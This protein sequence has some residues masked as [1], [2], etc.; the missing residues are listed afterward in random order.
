MIRLLKSCRFVIGRSFAV[1]LLVFPL[2]LV[3]P[4]RCFALITGGEGNQPLNDP[5]WPPGAAKV[6]NWPTRVAWWEGPPY[7]GGQ[8][9]AEC[10][11][12]AQ[13]VNEVLKAFQRIQ[14]SK[15]R[16]IVRD[17]IGFSF[18]LDPNGER[19]A[20]RSTKIDWEFTVWH[21]DGWQVQKRLP[22]RLSALS[23]ASE[24]AP[25]PEICIYCASVRWSEIQVPPGIEIVDQRLEAHGFKISDGRVIEGSIKD[26]AS[27][28]PLPATVRVESIQRKPGGGYEY[29]LEAET[30]ANAQGRWFFKDFSD[31]WSRLIASIDGYA[32]R[33]ICHVKYDRQPG[34]ERV[35]TLLAPA[36]QLSGRVIDQDGKPLKG[37]QIKLRDLSCDSASEYEIPESSEITS[38][39][40][41][42]FVLESLPQGTARLN[43]YLSGY[44]GPG[45]GLD[46]RI[47][48]DDVQLPLYKAASLRVHVRFGQPRAGS[49]YIVHIA[50]EGGNKIGSWGG[51]ANLDQ[52]DSVHFQNVPPGRYL[53]YGRPNPG[54]AGQQTKD[55]LVTLEGGRETVIEITAVS[56]Q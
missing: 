40:D 17:G 42:R 27:G 7:G 21:P 43:G 14:T 23:D 9:H 30:S 38:D 11:G 46:V 20:D 32:P 56:D 28:Q 4:V 54:G 55:V 13:V 36:A 29:Q 5:G 31:Q 16:L 47:P 33:I 22:P 2:S 45:L 25:I 37:V 26:A 8:W 50:P 53:V 35:D 24:A 34:W 41:G 18:W 10:K 52:H 6:F 49:G 15:K 51:S 44:H 48:G 39:S 1:W 19:R 3:N 12:D